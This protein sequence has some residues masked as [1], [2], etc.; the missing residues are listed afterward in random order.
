MKIEHMI[1]WGIL[2]VIALTFA[3]G[4]GGEKAKQR[5]DAAM[6]LVIA[7]VVLAILIYVAVAL[8]RA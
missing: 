3:I 5:F 8:L 1:G 2:G 4:L 6:S 7:L